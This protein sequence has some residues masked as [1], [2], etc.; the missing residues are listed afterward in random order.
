MYILV[1]DL[2]MRDVW[3]EKYCIFEQY[4]MVMNKFCNKEDIGKQYIL[5]C[6]KY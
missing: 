1:F 4:L 3:V 6:V 2:E 5:Y